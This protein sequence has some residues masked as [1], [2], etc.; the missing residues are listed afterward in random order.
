M[1]LYVQINYISEIYG[2]RIR[3]AITNNG[4]LMHISISDYNNNKTLS[5][6]AVTLYN[7]DGSVILRGF[8]AYTQASI[9][10]F[11]VRGL[12]IYRDMMNRTIKFLELLNKYYKWGV[13]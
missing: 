8:E 5:V 11:N 7:S 13:M 3:E 6:N 10:V 2:H 4:K 1:E 12:K 9:G